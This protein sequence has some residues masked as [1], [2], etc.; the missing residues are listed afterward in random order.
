MQV[1]TNGEIDKETLSF[2]V[3]EFFDA[4]FPCFKTLCSPT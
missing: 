2:H 3:Y 1:N 4:G